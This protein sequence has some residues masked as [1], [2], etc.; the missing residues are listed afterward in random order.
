MTASFIPVEGV[1][2]VEV[3]DAYYQNP[4]R[5]PTLWEDLCSRV[6]TFDPSEGKEVSTY[7]LNDPTDGLVDGGLPSWQPGEDPPAPRNKTGQPVI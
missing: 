2:R 7:Q 6:K 5:V 3:R 1:A 4:D